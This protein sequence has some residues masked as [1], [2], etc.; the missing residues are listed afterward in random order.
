MRKNLLIYLSLITVF[1]LGIYTILNVGSRVVGVHSPPAQTAVSTT[2]DSSNPAI[3]P[4]AKPAGRFQQP[5]ALLLLQL[6]VIVAATRSMGALFTRMGQPAVI[7]EMLAGILLG[8]SLLGWLAPRAEGFLFPVS[9]LGTLQML[10]QI[11]VILFMFLVGMELNVQALRSRAHAAVLISHAGILAPFMLGTALS[12][13]LYNSLAAS[14][15]KFIAFA[16]FMGIAMSITAFPVLARMIQQRGMNGTPLGTIAIASAAVDDVTAWCVLAI[17]VAIAGANNL[18]GAVVTIALA[19]AFT[20]IMLYLIRPR[21]PA[22]A[23]RISHGDS[24]HG[25]LMAAILVFVF[26]S[27]LV[28]E[29]IGIH[30]LFGAF[31]A[32]VA[33]PP[34]EKLDIPVKERLE[35]FSTGFLLPL[36]F[37]FT[38]LRTQIG[39][40][41]NWESWLVC[42]AIIGVAIAGKL[43]GTS[44]AARIAGMNWHDS[45]SMG[46]LM[47]TRGLI[48][49]IAL[50][51]GYDMGLLSAEIFAMMVIMALTTTFMAGPILNLLQS[52][53][54]RESAAIPEPIPVEESGI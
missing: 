29:S 50:N 22:L 47:N 7:G 40:L 42:A 32:G 37:A 27:A 46:A 52:R 9:S 6:I 20:F 21:L 49:L 8:P 2:E 41:N 53:T 39:L 36:F 48:E 28:T 11:G 34:P 4:E 26:G 17:V 23:A 13:A 15:V 45:L 10:S 5:L 35:T 1:G 12:I 16:L 30:A 38:G 25:L 18:G 24:R 31:L 54:N 44:V 14:G 3:Q 33:L 43:G 51:I 19:L